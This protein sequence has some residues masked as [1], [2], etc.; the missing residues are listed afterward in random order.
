M[1]INNKEIPIKEKDLIEL[2][3]TIEALSDTEL[4]SLLFHLEKNRA[5]TIVALLIKFNTSQ[6][7]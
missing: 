4:A 3:K 2:A 6:G 7:M 1:R 5:K